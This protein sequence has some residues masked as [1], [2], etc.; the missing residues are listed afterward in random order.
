[1]RIVVCVIPGVGRPTPT[2]TGVRPERIARYL[3]Q[4]SFNIVHTF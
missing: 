4:F 3:V 1:M 2:K